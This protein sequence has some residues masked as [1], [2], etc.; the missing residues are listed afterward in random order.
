[1]SETRARDT[2]NVS[3]E[4]VGIA[5]DVANLD[6]EKANYVYSATAPSS[7]WAG[8]LWMDTSGASPKAFVWNG[9]EWKAFSGASA[10]TFDEGAST[11]ATFSTLTDPDGDGKNYR[12]AAFTTSGAYSLELTDGGL[13]QI[14]LVGGGG[15][16]S[17]QGLAA[18]GSVLEGTV[19]LDAGTKSVVVADAGV[20][21][22]TGGSPSHSNGT[23]GGSSYIDDFVARGGPGDAF[24]RGAAPSPNPAAGDY[25]IT[26][27]AVTYPNA[28]Y[29]NGGA[30]QQNGK[31]G[32]VYV[33]VAI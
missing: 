31:P 18:T 26:G 7:P 8:D 10:A 14:L 22:A 30:A 5:I 32:V 17:L 21:I 12:L 2:A 24:D 15:G 13:A 23:H 16:G 6:A 11:G 29:G 27:S 1:M 28:T 25:S 9:S 20:A 19:L 4:L 33:R 3:T